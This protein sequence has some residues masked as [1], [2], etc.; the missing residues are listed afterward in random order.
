MNTYRGVEVKLHAF[1]TSALYLFSMVSFTNWS[2]ISGERASG[3]HLIGCWV[4]TRAGVGG[5]G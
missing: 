4:E 2:F 1:S 5:G 3:T